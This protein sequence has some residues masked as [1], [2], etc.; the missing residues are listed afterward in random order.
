MAQSGQDMILSLD[1]IIQHKM[2]DQ[3]VLLKHPKR[4]C[5]TDVDKL[6]IG[7]DAYIRARDQAMKGS[8]AKSSTGCGKFDRRSLREENS[9]DDDDFPEDPR[10]AAGQDDFDV[11]MIEDTYRKPLQL[12]KEENES[13]DS[14]FDDILNF[15]TAE[16]RS[17][18]RIRSQNWR[19]LPENLV[20]RP[21]GLKRLEAAPLDENERYKRVHNG[22]VQKKT[23][24]RTNSFSSV[25]SKVSNCKAGTFVEKGSF[26][27]KFGNRNRDQRNEEAIIGIERAKHFKVNRL[28]QE[29]ASAGPPVNIN[30]NWNGFFEGFAKCVDKVAPAAEK[31]EDSSSELAATAMRLLSMLQQK[32][33]KEKDQKYNMEIQKEISTI[34]RRPI[35]FEDHGDGYPDIVATSGVGV[36]DYDAGQPHSTTLPFNIR[37][38]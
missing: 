7:L 33:D 21:I 36:D 32:R 10:N 9:S 15:R 4:E 8:K 26:T 37:F 35:V 12:I 20:D 18:I 14:N 31:K 38:A 13:N 24:S 3:F 28:A 27:Y 23:K 29:A 30:M 11:E 1:E 6:N 2:K 19:L 22:R 5:N 25:D 34:Q 16:S 17:G